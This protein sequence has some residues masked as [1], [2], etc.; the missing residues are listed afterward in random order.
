MFYVVRAWTAV[1]VTTFFSGRPI[2]RAPNRFQ[3]LRK[4]AAHPNIPFSV[5]LSGGGY[6]AAVMHAGVLSALEDLHYIPTNISGVSG[7]AIYRCIL[8]NRR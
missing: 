5:A 4:N 8:F 7:G 3:Q 6:R 2:M 1:S